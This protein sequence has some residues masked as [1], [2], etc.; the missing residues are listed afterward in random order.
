MFS[1]DISHNTQEYTENIFSYLSLSDSANDKNKLQQL[2]KI[3]E[4]KQKE[5]TVLGSVRFHYAKLNEC[6]V[7]LNSSRQVQ[8]DTNFQQSGNHTHSIQLAAS[9]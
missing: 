1:L 3:R 7:V 5:L 2:V 4:F 8:L 6:F 9:V